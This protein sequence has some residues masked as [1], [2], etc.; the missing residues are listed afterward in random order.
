MVFESIVHTCFCHIDDG[1]SCVGV[2]TFD[3]TKKRRLHISG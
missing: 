1:T 3:V 2:P